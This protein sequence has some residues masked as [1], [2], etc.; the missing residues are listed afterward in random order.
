[1]A[2]KKAPEGAFYLSL[3]VAILA[4]SILERFAGLESR[5]L[6]GR[7]LDFLARVAW[8]YARASSSL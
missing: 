4:N 3:Q 7:D 2:N 1:L 6:H 8:I 5:E